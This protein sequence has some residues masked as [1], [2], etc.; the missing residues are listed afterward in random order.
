MCKEIKMSGKAGPLTLFW[1][2]D[3]LSQ[4]SQRHVECRRD[5]RGRA[6]CGEELS[7]ARSVSVFSV[8]TTTPPN[9]GTAEISDC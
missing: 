6:A 8:N 5:W 9:G 4:A 7:V 1:S 2:G 3:G